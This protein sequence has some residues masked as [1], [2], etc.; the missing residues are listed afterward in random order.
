M[1]YLKRIILSLLFLL[2]TG[3]VS[4]LA[5]QTGSNYDYFNQW[6]QF[7]QNYIKLLVS[8]DGFYRVSENDLTAAG[9]NT[10]G[11]DPA[12][13]QVFY[14]GQEIPIRTVSNGAQL[15][16]F[17]FLGKRNDGHLDSLI[18]RSVS[19]PY[20]Y[21][22]EQ[23]PN[24]FS[25]FFSDT[26]AYFIT[27]GNV[28]TNRY[29]EI[30][31]TNYAAYN[32]E[33][34]YR[35]RALNE[36]VERYFPGGGSNNNPYHVLNPDYVT[37]EGFI[38]NKFEFGGPPNSGISIVNTPGF[39][40]SGSPSKVAGRVVHTTTSSQHIL[41]I[42]VD[43][44]EHFRDTTQNINIRT[45]EFNTTQPLSNNTTIR[46]VA[47][48][49]GS[50][51]DAGSPC[52]NY[53]EYDRTF[54]MEDSATTI[55]RG[56]SRTDTTYMRFY[57][58]DVTGEAW[59]Y[60][61]VLQKLVAATVS[62]DTLS[63]LVPGYAGARDLYVYTDK[64]ILSPV[65][66]NQTSLANLS[67][68]GNGA[69]FV[70]ITHRRFAN[71]AREYALY[72][73]TCTVNQM[74]SKVVYVDEIYDEFG[75]GSLN[76]LA[77]KNFC[78]YTLDNWSITPRFFLL[79][80]KGRSAP[81]LDNTANY[82]PTFG[83]P[84]NDYEYVSN[85]D[86]ITPSVTPE[87]AIGRVA[88]FED[89]EGLIY[90]AKVDEYEHMDYQS[91]MKEAVFLGGGKTQS[92][93]DA[94]GI[95]M[96]DVFKPYLENA[97]MGG[98]VFTFQASNSGNVSN[99][100]KT[101][102]E[103]INQG[104]GLIHFFGHSGTNIFDVDILE[105]KLY[106]NF[107][108]YPFMVAFGCYGGDFNNLIPSFG[109]RFILEPDRGSIG[110]LANTTAGF[111]QQLRIFG[112]DFYEN[113][114]GDYYG[115]PIGVVLQKTIEQFAISGNF[116]SNILTVNH[117]K[118]MNLQGDPSVVLRFPTKPDLR[119]TDSDLFFEPDNISALDN[120]YLLNLIVHNDGQTFSDSFQ[121][122]I[123]H[124]AP[125]GSVI[126]Y[127]EQ[128]FGPIDYIDTISYPIL[129]TLGPELAGLNDYQVFIDAVDTLDE[130]L[131]IN[132]RLNYE[133]VIQGNIPAII[134][135]Y[136]Y[137]IVDSPKVTLSASTFIITKD[138]NLAYEFEID[139][140]HDFI[141]GFRSG[142]GRI[143]GTAS[144]GEWNVPL[145]LQPGQVYY[146]R[147][148]LADV[149]PIQWNESSFKYIPGK[150]GWSQSDEPQFFFDPT[151]QISMDEVNRIWSF[152]QFS[153]NLH[154]YIRS[155]GD[156]EGN[157]EFFLGSFTSNNF[158]NDGVCYMAISQ[159]SLE[160]SFLNTFYGDWNFVS[161]PDP[162]G[163]VED[164]LQPMLEHIINTTEGDYFLLVTSQEPRFSDWLPKW[165]QALE[166]IGVSAQQVEGLQNGDRMIVLGR[167]GGLPGTATVIREP[168]LPIGT[169]PPR[170]D[171]LID[172]S[173][174]YDSAMVS[175]TKIGPSDNWA[176]FNMD[177]STIDA[178]NQENIVTSIFGVRRD[179]TES[180][181]FN[182][183]E[184]GLEAIASI[185]SDEFPF[186]RLEARVED[187][188]FRTAPQMD[189]WEVYFEPAPDA[190][191]DPSF[192]FAIPDTID[193]G[194]IIDLRMGARNVT[195]FDMDSLLV[196]FTLQRADRSSQV[197]GEKRFAPLAANQ[198][199]EL[200]YKFHT[201]GRDLDGLATLI[202]E[203]NPDLDQVEQHEFNNFYFHRM[204]V[205]TDKVGPILDVTVD[206]K[207]LMDGDIV[208]PEPE[209][210][211]QLND[212]NKYLPVS[213]S[214]S[215][216]K[217]WFGTER[218]FQ[219]NEQIF[220]DGNPKIESNVGLLPE[221]KANLTFHPGLLS[222]GEY[223]L[224]V[225][226]YDFKGNA[227]GSDEYVIHFNVVN[228]KAVSKVLPYPNPFSTSARFV[229]TLTGGE[230]PYVF[231][232]RIYTITGRLIRTIDMLANEDVYMGRNISETIWDG[233]DEFG[234]Q[235]ANGVYIYKAHIKF[236]DRFGVN[237]RDEGIDQYFN[238]SG[239][240][241]IYLMR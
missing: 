1:E 178:F 196:R 113:M 127:P 31:P 191:V 6:Y 187:R 192:A 87:A 29:D 12:N 227:S 118:Q 63:F 228:E 53:I 70:I 137:A 239:F 79:W 143:T 241:K 46:Y 219:L 194:Q 147:V 199:M 117:A 190:T 58:A 38:G 159:K 80:G 7:N 224:A 128:N 206:G 76:P 20:G 183:L 121:L 78:K 107:N 211:I 77:I 144:G 86:R 200:D 142:S 232:I 120:E 13:L 69:E 18:Y 125:N 198:A 66:Q 129:N 27:W 217:I 36:H 15:N 111:L 68:P 16:Y 57:K 184:T 231:E 139:T 93:Q 21:D 214:D 171:L 163:F 97:P 140:T 104:V 61:P 33:P 240:G 222:D 174:S 74:S 42:Q 102:E 220:I 152:D 146:W 75:Y 156:F 44:T 201:A 186:I 203:L 26:S 136:E 48:G 126:T 209:I 168:N 149:Y 73:D 216:Y 9:V 215:T 82:I 177:W 81:K 108:R 180:L 109:E 22:P 164:P 35:Y 54:D 45:R 103:V 5:A 89:S 30:S 182:D 64:S 235:L 134:S 179:K 65:I 160:P 153:R 59:L 195:E 19:P 175:S 24:R 208:S 155:F 210:V 51:P 135:P 14:R 83:E 72:R 25:S 157:P 229:Y 226:G 106:Q 141:S 40:N 67:D 207:R 116:T 4:E 170:H 105:A 131:E 233:T 212:D 154:A 133:V 3:Q 100:N 91:W 34:W 189:F 88:I 11:L 84:A 50:S 99:T 2:A 8:K 96:G 172:L 165:F 148:R 197:I 37:G 92:E 114:F 150:T 43:G 47:L 173:A 98:K 221:N 213:I 41:A 218:T 17:E 90:L 55:V 23:Q 123:T 101:S 151:S 71:S 115:E 10:S 234:D 185:D 176:E 167:K 94:I 145:D 119:I 223:T 49:Q 181:L 110:Y 238:K 188:F 122:Q 130:Y 230:L 132:N 28:G 85:F 237:E 225:Q 62:G 204:Y 236:R 56:W 169:Q 162:G 161:A 32:A 124:R 112:D 193:E 158:P 60:D 138:D 95:A 52:W 205:Q 166:M 39:A 202:I